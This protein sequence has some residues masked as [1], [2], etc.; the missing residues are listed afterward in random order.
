MRNTIFSLVGISILISILILSCQPNVSIETAQYAVNGQKLYA[1]HCQNC[2]GAKGEGLGMLYPP[3]TDTAYLQ[4]HR[5]K[6]ACI[7]KNGLSGPIEI[8]GI[9]YEGD[10]PG[11]QELSEI[12]I[13]YI[14][15]YITT[16][17]GN[18]TETYTQDEVKSSLE[19]CLYK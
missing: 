12:D 4:Q 13:A 3:L 8:N 2:H 1:A 19:D 15:T 7:V 18:S 11:I 5:E 17:F 6:L 9:M 14:L 16:T 10:M